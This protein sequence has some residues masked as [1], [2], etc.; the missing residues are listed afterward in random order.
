MGSIYRIQ[1]LFFNN[2]NREESKL[3]C[4]GISKVFYRLDS[5][6]LKNHRFNSFVF[7]KQFSKRWIWY[8]DLSLEIY[9][10]NYILIY[11]S[12]LLI[13]NQRALIDVRIDRKQG[14]IHRSIFFLGYIVVTKIIN[15]AYNCEII[16]SIQSFSQFYLR[17]E[18]VD[19]VPPVAVKFPFEIM[20]H[21]DV[22]INKTYRSIAHNILTDSIR[23]TFYSDIGRFEKK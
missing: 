18:T 2:S 6:W 23:V 10:I 4:S 22:T 1:K 16:T 15:I 7:L 11:Y 8:T 9:S 17:F 13:I 5:F 21:R 19:T 12:F 14:E 20:F 3:L